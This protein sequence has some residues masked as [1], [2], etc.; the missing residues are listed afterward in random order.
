ML[1]PKSDFCFFTFAPPTD[2]EEADHIPFT[3]Q[4]ASTWTHIGPPLDI[5]SL[6]SSFD[7]WQRGTFLSGDIL[8]LLIPFLNF[9]HD[10]LEQSHMTHYCLTIRA[11]KATTE[12][13]IP[14]WHVDRRF[15]DA[16][17]PQEKFLGE[18]E[19]EKRRPDNRQNPS[20]LKLAT[21]LVGPG[22]LFLKDGKRGRQLQKEI[23]KKLKLEQT[24]M[25]HYAVGEG[26]VCSS[27]RCLGCAD[28]AQNVR[29]R[30]AE[31]I[32]KR[33]M[34]TV[35]TEMGQAAVFRVDGYNICDGEPA[36]HSEPVMSEGDRVFVHVVPGREGELRRLVKVCICS[37]IIVVRF[38]QEF[39]VRYTACFGSLS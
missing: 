36:M 17:F 1:L 19:N 3:I 20:S 4:T 21:A 25:G 29:F 12:F 22:T 33:K 16:D 27:F 9:L 5:S 38:P 32:K 15:F 11:Q 30:L 14:R 6:P 31:E 39:L 34:E 13:D 10:F 26:H 37:P 24:K 2:P 8:K 35:S 28:M 23:E 18:R 7:T